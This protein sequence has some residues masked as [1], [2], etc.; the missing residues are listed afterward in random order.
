MSEIL[1]PF[2]DDRSP[3][4]ES[5]KASCFLCGKAVDPLDSHRGGYEIGPGARLPIHLP[6]I[7]PYVSNRGIDVKV[8]LAYRRAIYDMAARQLKVAGLK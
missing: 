7:A 4:I 2:D 1:R 6:C 5:G 3:E 8:E